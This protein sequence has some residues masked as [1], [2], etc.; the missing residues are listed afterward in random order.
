MAWFLR[1]T[2]SPAMLRGK[3]YSLVSDFESRCAR[4]FR[5]CACHTKNCTRTKIQRPPGSISLVPFPSRERE[6]WNILHDFFCSSIQIHICKHC[7]SDCIV[8]VPRR[9]YPFACQDSKFCHMN[10]GRRRIMWLAIFGWNHFR[11][12]PF[13][14]HLWR[15]ILPHANTCMCI[16]KS[17]SL[18]LYSCIM[19]QY[20][21]TYMYGHRTHT[22]TTLTHSLTTH[23]LSVATRVRS[24]YVP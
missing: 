11:L 10:E 13:Q 16:Y 8:V 12:W 20:D 23:Q 5:F 15:H 18:P 2:T 19:L 7:T 24:T 3:R 1:M 14:V 21:A 22:C 17:V 9:S 6:E 4:R